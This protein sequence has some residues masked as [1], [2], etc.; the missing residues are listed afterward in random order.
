MARGSATI[1]PT[2]IPRIE[3]GEGILKHHLHLAALRAKFFPAQR[4]KIA[5]P[6]NWISPLSGSISP[7][8]HAR[9]VVVFPRSPLFA[10]DG[11]RLASGNGKSSRPSTAVKRAPL[12][13]L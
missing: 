9:P 10:D 1:S 4:E 7:Q 5:F 3:R 2:R 11:E 8:E 12:S 13:S 6:W